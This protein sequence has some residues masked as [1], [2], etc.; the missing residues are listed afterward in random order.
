MRRHVSHPQLLWINTGAQPASRAKLPFGY[1][2]NRQHESALDRGK[3]TP[4]PS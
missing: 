3:F 4:A 2:E 1:V